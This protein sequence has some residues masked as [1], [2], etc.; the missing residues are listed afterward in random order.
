MEKIYMNM[1]TG[2]ITE[3]HRTAV[4]WYRTGAEVGIFVNGED[5]P[6]LTWYH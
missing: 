1:E 5:K 2:E 6:R 3:N 4:E